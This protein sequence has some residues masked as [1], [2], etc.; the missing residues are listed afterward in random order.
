MLAEEIEKSRV[1]L[2]GRSARERDGTPFP[3]FFPAVP[4]GF[5]SPAEKESEEP[6]DI[7][8]YLI[9]NPET[10]FFVRVEGESM[11][12]AGILPGDILVVDRSLTPRNHSIVVVALNGELLVKRWEE[13]KEGVYLSPAHPD[14]PAIRVTPEMDLYVWGVVIGRFGRL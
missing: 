1:T 9:R 7:H 12:E 8:E 4:A 10:T 13:R 5:P 3:L 11:K 6:L 14:R 2:V